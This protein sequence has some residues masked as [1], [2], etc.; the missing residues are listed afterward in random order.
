MSQTWT[1]RVLTGLSQLEAGQLEAA[2]LVPVVNTT[3]QGVRQ[4]LEHFRQSAADD[5]EISQTEASQAEKSLLALA[6]SLESLSQCL[7]QGGREDWSGWRRR[8]QSS[9][10][11]IRRLRDKGRQGPTSQPLVNRLL[12][13]LEAWLRGDP[14]PEATYQILEWIPALEEH[15]NCV[16]SQMEEP[17]RSALNQCL[18]PA[19]R[20]LNRW[21]SVVEESPPEGSGQWPEILKQS[22]AE[23]DSLL[24]HQVEAD[25]SA[26]P[27]AFPILNVL[28]TALEQGLPQAPALARQSALLLKLQ[29][30]PEVLEQVQLLEVLDRLAEGHQEADQLMQQAEQTA[31]LLR[32]YATDDSLVDVTS[33]DGDSPSSL[34][35]GKLPPML[36]SVYQL[37]GEFVE[38][39]RSASDL[40]STREN[41]QGLV[42]RFEARPGM[43]GE[44]GLALAL[45]DLTAVVEVLQEMEVSPSRDLLN[46]LEEVLED[47]AE[48]LGQLKNRTATS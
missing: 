45:E 39:R 10:D 32:V 24:S 14:V 48:S 30:S 40:I 6:Q 16:I 20:T 1:D 34:K 46:E 41:L 36:A 8:I 31:L 27:S 22:V 5:P 18:E 12:L 13:H 19:R 25:W 26:G 4:Q 7:G 44:S 28:L 17:A 29:L 21:R 2:S 43:G 11:I 33:L 47:C 35:A 9:L 15:W 38:R 37:A 3:A 42:A 23:F